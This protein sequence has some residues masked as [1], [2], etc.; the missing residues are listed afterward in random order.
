[1]PSDDRRTPME[2]A[3]DKRLTDLNSQNYEAET[4]RILGLFKRYAER[5]H[6]VTAPGD[7]DG[8]LCR[9]FARALRRAT[10]GD[11]SPL[12]AATAEPDD[13]LQGIQASSA[14]RY[15]AYVRSVSRVVCRRSARRHQPRPPEQ[16]HGAA[17]G[18]HRRPRPPVLALGGP[19]TLSVAHGRPRR[20]ADRR[21]RAGRRRAPAGAARPRARVRHR[22]LGC[23]RR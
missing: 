3:I 18:G 6:G 22:P 21:H 20:R 10:D 19:R 15:Y 16:S 23:P 13:D 4:K 8:D 14:L 5:K 2:R 7:V 1:M 9:Q 11:A 12:D 17:A